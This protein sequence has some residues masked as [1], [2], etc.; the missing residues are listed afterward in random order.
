MT[1]ETCD[2]CVNPVKKGEQFCGK[3]I[4]IIKRVCKLL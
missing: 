1:Y 2:G 4:M 3:C